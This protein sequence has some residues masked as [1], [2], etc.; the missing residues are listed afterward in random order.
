MVR[1]PSASAGGFYWD[2]VPLSHKSPERKRRDVSPVVRDPSASAGGFYWDGVP[3]PHPSPQRKQG[4]AGCLT[5]WGADSS[6]SRFGLA[7]DGSEDSV[8]YAAPPSVA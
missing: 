1:D 4:N 5:G 7:W 2:G 3:L 8:P 6:R